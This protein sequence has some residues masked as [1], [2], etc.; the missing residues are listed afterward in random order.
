M[1]PNNEG[2]SASGD[3]G[4]PAVALRDELATTLTANG[5]DVGKRPRVI[6]GEELFPTPFP[7]KVL[8]NLTCAQLLE[9]AEEFFRQG[10][11]AAS[12]VPP[13]T[14]ASQYYYMTGASYLHA[15]QNN[16]LVIVEGTNPPQP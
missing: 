5:I 1:S 16:C 8:G 15:W 11:L 10:L 14:L 13:D 4:R 6:E 9:T 2:P 3:A 7:P 12:Q